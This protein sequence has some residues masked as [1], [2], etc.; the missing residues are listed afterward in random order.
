MT[1]VTHLTVE[2]GG[3]QKTRRIHLREISGDLDSP[4]ETVGQDLRAAR[5]RRGDDLA[6]VSKALKIRKDH[7]EALEE[8]RIENLP[9]RAYAVG[10]VRT[11]A[12][13]LGL[14][15]GQT[16]ERFKSQ[17]AGRTDDATPT[18]TVIDEDEHRRL[19]QGWKIIAAVVLL[20]F[21]YGAYHLLVP[22]A[23][24][25]LSPPVA[26]VPAQYAP[27]PVIAKK[28]PPKPVVQTPPVQT[29]T[30]ASTAIPPGT[31]PVTSDQS[32]A[33]PGTVPAPQQEAAIPE[34]KVYGQLNHNAR[35]VL[36]LK[37]P[38]RIL[39]QGA[40]GTTYI[41]RTLNAGDTYMVPDQVG[42]TLTTAD[43]GAIEVELDGT[44][45]GTAGKKGQIGESVSLDPQAIADRYN[46]HPG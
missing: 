15:A 38:T 33:P 14:D 40:D 37:A 1:K 3:G 8:D 10:F 11:Y 25:M 34:G 5:Q 41:N 7:L 12:D 19:P 36:R 20:L 24:K 45:M 23:D 42:V 43:A 31:A 35:V 26:P 44:V 29:A 21:A 28:L 39:V 2:E 4:L 30:T 9:G 22:A 16:V 27:K 18:I 6:T 46:G 32:A 17:I 13:Y